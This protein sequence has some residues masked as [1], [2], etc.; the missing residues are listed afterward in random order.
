MALVGI[1]F[2]AAAI[3]T[4][5]P[6]TRFGHASGPLDAWRWARWSLVAAVAAVAG[7]AVWA[8][9]WWRPRVVDRT[10]ALVLT[11]LGGIVA[12]AAAL[13]AVFPPSLTKGTVVPWLEAVAGMAAAAVAIRA[14]RAGGTS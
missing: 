11:V 5:L 6:W 13:A 3:L 12:A 7:L 8:L 1:A 4:L 10:A 9:Q 14:A 2:A